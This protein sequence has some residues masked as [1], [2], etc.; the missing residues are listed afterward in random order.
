MDFLQAMNGVIL[1]HGKSD[2]ETPG[3]ADNSTGGSA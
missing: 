3:G 1:R 2:N